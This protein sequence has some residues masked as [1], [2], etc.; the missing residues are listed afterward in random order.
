MLR[1]FS[2]QEANYA[3]FRQISV[4]YGM[5]FDYNRNSGMTAVDRWSAQNNTSKET[6]WQHK[7]LGK[8]LRRAGF[9]RTR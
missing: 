8:V 3:D 2:G 9:G 6:L 5:K 7:K 1:N 4:A